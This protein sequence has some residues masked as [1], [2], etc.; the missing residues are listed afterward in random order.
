VKRLVRLV[1]RPSPATVIS[2]IALFVTLGGVSYGVATSSIDSREIADGTVRGK[3]VRNNNLT[4]S[5]LR[6][7]DV[8][9]IDIRNNTIRGRDLAAKTLTDD[10]I[11]ES[12]LTQVAGAVN[13]AQLGGLPAGEYARSAQEPVRIVGAPGQPEFEPGFVPA[14]GDRLPPGFWQDSLGVVH[15]QGT[16]S[17]EIGHAFTLPSSYRPAGSAVFAVAGVP[18]AEIAIDA[19]GTVVVGHSGLTPLD[20]IS[21][22][23][24]R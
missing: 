17:G 11:D 16:V 10:Q 3:D 21:F 1:R 15:L 23:A 18:D 5:D 19:A 14:P 13:A 8:R 6:N 2:C 20:G 22:R 7:N 4:T 9:G 12:K 24:A